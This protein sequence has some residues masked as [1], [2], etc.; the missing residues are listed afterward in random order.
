MLRASD[1][2]PPHRF[3]VL[4]YLM[5]EDEFV[6]H[7]LVTPPLRF[8]V[9]DAIAHEMVAHGVCITWITWSRGWSPGIQ[10][11][12][13]HDTGVWKITKKRASESAPYRVFARLDRGLQHWRH[14]GPHVTLNP[15]DP[16]EPSPHHADN[17][18]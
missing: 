14:L 5:E 2:G 13:L 17:V 18:T 15:L 7:A 9:D 6:R 12:A 16:G 3:P 4:M 10:E 1:P 8:R 11:R